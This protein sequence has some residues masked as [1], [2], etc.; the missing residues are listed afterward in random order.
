MSRST[1]FRA[2]AFAALAAC[3]GGDDAAALD[4]AAL[5][6]AL[7]G[8]PESNGGFV[9]PFAVTKANTKSGGVWTEVGDADWSCLGAPSTDQPSTGTIAIAG[10]I[11]DFQTGNGVGDASITAWGTSPLMML[12]TASS[13]N[14]AATRGDFSMTLGMLP[15][16]TRR[17]GFTLIAVDHVSTVVLGRYYAPANA[18]TDTVAMISQATALA[19]PAFI[20]LARDPTK[21]VYIGEMRDCQGRAVS[22]AV[23]GVSF[24]PSTFTNAGGETF[25]FSAGS[26]SLPVRHTVEPLMNNDGQFT[27]VNVAPGSTLFVQVWGFRSLAELNAGTLTLLG[28]IAA[29]SQPDQYV[30]LRLDPRRT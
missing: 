11:T 8:R 3:S 28:E 5:D 24:V 23:A 22:N 17:Y 21:A 6:A 29:P 25:Y 9:T 20:G 27:I 30:S 14:V 7:D 19:L 1:T 26:T 13:S 12:G 2:T 10:R 4:A 16:G 18:A 15:S